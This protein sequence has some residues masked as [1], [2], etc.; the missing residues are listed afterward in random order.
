MNESPEGIKEKKFQ[1]YQKALQEQQ[2]NVVTKVALLRYMTKEA[3]ER[4]NRVKLVKPDTAK[5][6]EMA[7]LQALQ[8][9]QIRDRVTD[10]QLKQ[11]LDEITQPKNKKFHVFKK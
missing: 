8:A 2:V 9:G 11:I 1:E 7:L 3:R 6:V 4:L 10:V 5:Q